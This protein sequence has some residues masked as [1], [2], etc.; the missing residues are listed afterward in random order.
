MKTS[1]SISQTHFDNQPAFKLD[2][3]E[4]VKEGFVVPEDTYLATKNEDGQWQLLNELKETASLHDKSFKSLGLWTDSAKT[5]KTFLGFTV[6]EGREKDGEVQKDEVVPLKKWARKQKCF[7]Y[8]G[9]DFS[10]DYHDKFKVREME[11]SPQG[12]DINLT[13]EWKAKR[14][15]RGAFA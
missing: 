13:A 8:V 5:E 15:R 1:V 11:L 6:S 7:K 3:S 9:A 14:V 10:Y 12:S 2:K 4:S